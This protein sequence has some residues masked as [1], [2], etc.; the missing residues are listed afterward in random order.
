MLEENTHMCFCPLEGVI[1]VI[2]K[3]WALLIVNVIGNYERL[4]FNKLMQELGYISPKTLSDTLKELQKEGLVKKDTFAEIPPRVEY[5]LTKDGVELRKAIIPLLKWA[6]TRTN[7]K[8]KK[9]DPACREIPAH[10]VRLAAPS[11]KDT[12]PQTCPKAI[13]KQ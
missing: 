2:S 9:C 12:M 13:L 8:K 1:D 7:V 4:R 11:E 3:K 5:S 10:R 6:A